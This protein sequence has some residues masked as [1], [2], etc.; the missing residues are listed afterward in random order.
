MMNRESLVFCCVSLS[1]TLLVCVAGFVLAALPHDVVDA[2]KRPVPAETL[3][4]IDIGGGFGKV[5]VI[6]LIGFYIEAPPAP[7]VAGGSASPAVRRFS[8]C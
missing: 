3:P 5:S 8:G 2:A 7:Q 6:D 4:D 1:V